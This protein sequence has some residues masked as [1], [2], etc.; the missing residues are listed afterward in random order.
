MVPSPFKNE[1]LKETHGLK[2]KKFIQTLYYEIQIC[3]IIMR[4]N[5]LNTVKFLHYAIK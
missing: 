2:L 5:V 3:A 1:E 4:L